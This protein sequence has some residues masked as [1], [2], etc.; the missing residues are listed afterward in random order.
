MR[1]YSTSTM[2]DILLSMNSCCHIEEPT[3]STGLKLQIFN[4]S[5]LLIKMDYVQSSDTKIL[6][7]QKKNLTDCWL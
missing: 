6:T 5:D 4:M 3:K 7:S 1:F 2:A